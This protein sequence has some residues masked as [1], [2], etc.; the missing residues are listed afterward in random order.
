[1]IAQIVETAE[2]AEIAKI[3]KVADNDKIGEIAKI[4]Q[5]AETDIIR[6]TKTFEIWVCFGNIDGFFEKKTWI[7]FKIANLE[8]FV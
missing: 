5:S 2:I 4:A 7:S 8:I 3:A 1:M 6:F